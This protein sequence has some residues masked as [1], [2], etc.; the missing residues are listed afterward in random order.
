MKQIF[1][2]F[3]ISLLCIGTTSAQLGINFSSAADVTPGGQVTVDV[4]VE[5]FDNIVLFQFGVLWDPTVLSY[6]SL[7]NVVGNPPLPD[8]SEGG[9]IGTPPVSALLDDG[10]IW[11][12]WNEANTDQVTIPDGTILFSIVLDVIGD[13]C[14]ETTFSVGPILGPVEVYNDNTFSNNIGVTA[15]DGLVNIDGDDCNGMGT[16]CDNFNGIV[17][18]IDDVNA[19]AGE[20]VCVPVTVDNFEDIESASI[21]VT[22]D[23]SIVDYTMITNFALPGSLQFNDTNVSNGELAVLWTDPLGNQNSLPN[24]AVIFE[25]CFDAVGSVGQT[26]VINFGDLPDIGTGFE[27]EFSSMSVAIPFCVTEG[28]IT[29]IDPS[30]EPFV[31]AGNS[32]IGTQG[33][34]VCVDY[35]TE[36]FTDIS[37]IQLNIMW[38]MAVIDFDEVAMVNTDL[39][40]F[41]VSSFNSVA[42][43]KLRLTWNSTGGDG[44]DLPDGSLLFQL[45]FDAIGACESETDLMYVSFGGINTEIGDGAGNSIPASMYDLQEGDVTITCPP[46]GCTVTVT[47]VSCNGGNNGSVAVSFDG[48][49]NPSCEWKNSDGVVIGSACNLSGQMAGNFTLCV[50]TGGTTTTK[51]VT[52][53]E[54]D[55]IDI[56]VTVMDASCN[57]N[58]SADIVITGG[59]GGNTIAWDPPGSNPMDL[60]EGDYGI[61]V[62]DSQMCTESASFSVGITN[63]PLDVTVTVT[64]TSCSDSEDGTINFTASGGC[65]PYTC[66]GCDGMFAPGSY[67]VTISDSDGQSES[68]EVFITAPAAIEIALLNGPD[69]LTSTGTDGFIN[70]NG[71]GGTGALSYSWTSIGGFTSNTQNINGLG[72]DTYT[73]CAT[74]QNNCQTCSSWEIILDDPGSAPSITNTDSTPNSC[75]GLI[76]TDCDGSIFAAVVGATSITVNGDAVTE[77]DLT[78]LCAGEYVIVATNGN[79]ST[80]ETITV[81]EPDQIEIDVDTFCASE[82]TDDGSIELTVT[83]GTG[84]YTYT[85][86]DP[87]LMGSN[88]SF[89]AVGSYNVLIEDINGCQAMEQMITVPSCT[90]MGID[91]FEALNILTPNG[92]GMNDFFMINCAEQNSGTLTVYDRYGQDVYSEVGYSNGWDGRDNNGRILNEG[93]YMWVLEVDFG[94]G[95]RELYKG[96]VTVLRDL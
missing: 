16:G 45:C 81:G 83:G 22:W 49:S 77:V 50:T 73:V 48:G 14:D 1:L 91:C 8:F 94:N 51:D 26:S 28:S 71:T 65:A 92:D 13:P 11:T 76:D 10:E 95:Q 5:D 38:D 86:G 61:T 96:T 34:Q 18:T 58:G 47:D 39:G 64:M 78:G 69:E 17:L 43:D 63:E 44:E 19:E 20:S 70:I 36:N 53:D 54:P 29:I 30:V 79:G 32:V 85:W 66:V 12:S 75:F 40:G 7:T 6:N 23:E 72:P 42:D 87:D 9:N 88:P 25:I 55:P 80:E 62:T 52:I 4:S 24:G 67:N 82:D 33:E 27:M 59:N 2:S 21:G 68:A 35:T 3:C 74:D 60:P 46:D 31:I 15:T 90:V 93:G 89:L 56:Q 84:P 57:G 41:S 37:S